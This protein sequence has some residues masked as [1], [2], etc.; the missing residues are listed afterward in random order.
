MNALEADF[1]VVLRPDLP[2]TV[3]E[4]YDEFCSGRVKSVNGVS[5]SFF[6]CT[7][8][9]ETGR[10]LKMEVLIGDESEIPHPVQIPFEMVLLISGAGRALPKL[11]GFHP[12]STT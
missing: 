11:F 10:F 2:A 5:L 8:I 6:A 12:H 4:F 9:D 3:A 1:W 7:E